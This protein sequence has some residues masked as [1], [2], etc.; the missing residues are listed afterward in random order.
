MRKRDILP[1][2]AGDVITRDHGYMRGHGTYIDQDV[3]W[4]SIAGIVE[5]VNKL[6]QR[7][8]AEHFQ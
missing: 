1:W 3:L 4:A 7:I 6:D 8:G 5:R 2:G